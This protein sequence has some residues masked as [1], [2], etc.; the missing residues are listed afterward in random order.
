MNNH[1]KPEDVEDTTVAV[2][3]NTYDRMM[4]RDTIANVEHTG[5]SEVFRWDTEYGVTDAGFIKKVSDHYPIY[6]EFR[7][8][9]P[10]DD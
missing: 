2:S 10:D 7:T 1:I 8:D 6:A 9:L 5:K 4:T 3:D